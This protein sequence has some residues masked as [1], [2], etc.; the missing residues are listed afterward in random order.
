MFVVFASDGLHVQKANENLTITKG[1][2]DEA[3][4]AS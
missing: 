1:E 4:K 3:C 2:L